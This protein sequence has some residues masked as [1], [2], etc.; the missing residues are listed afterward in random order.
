MAGAVDS[1]CVQMVRARLVALFTFTLLL[2]CACGCHHDAPAPVSGGTTGVTPSDAGQ[3]A[4][5]ETVVKVEDDGKTIDVKTGAT[6]AFK[7]AG[8]SGTGYAW[9]AGAVDASVL[10][11]QGERQVERLSDA[12]GG[13]K[14]DVLRFVAKGPGTVVVQVDLKRPW[15]DQP[16]AKTVKVTVK[17]K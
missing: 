17:V 16:V 1:V 14:L 6:L 8:N 7:L 15:G 5:D 9:V 12:P 4:S 10:V 11:P 13:A 2:A 3:P